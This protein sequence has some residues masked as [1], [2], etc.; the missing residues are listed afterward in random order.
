MQLRPEKLRRG[1][2]FLLICVMSVLLWNRAGWGQDASEKQAAL[3]LLKSSVE[4]AHA[5]VK[6]EPDI[7]Q[8]YSKRFSGD[9]KSFHVEM[10]MVT[11]ETNTVVV[12][13]L[14]HIETIRADFARID[15]AEQTGKRSMRIV[16]RGNASCI[17][18]YEDLSNTSFDCNECENG[19][20]C[21]YRREQVSEF[22]MSFCDPSASIDAIDALNFIASNTRP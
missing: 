12:S 19:P 9:E 14:T 3:E 16:C 17:D 11:N 15:R 8:R 20:V 21:C 6:P 10:R 7:T 4:C 18:R 2:G 1:I 22:K 13:D 5:A